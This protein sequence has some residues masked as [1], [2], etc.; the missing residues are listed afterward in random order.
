MKNFLVEIGT[1]ELPFKNLPQLAESFT[2]NLVNE[3]EKYYLCYEEVKW[4]ATPRRLAIKVTNLIQSQDSTSINQLPIF[5]PLLHRSNQVRSN[6]KSNHNFLF[7]QKKKKFLQR[8]KHQFLMSKNVHENNIIN[9]LPEIVKNSLVNISQY[10]LMRW[11]NNNIKFIR[12]IKTIILFFGKK[13][14]NSLILGIKTNTKIYGHQFI[15]KWEIHLTSAD[16]YLDVLKEKGKVLANYQER[17]EL[18]RNDLEY[19]SSLLEG[20]VDINEKILDEVTSQVEWPVILKANFEK[21]FLQIPLL[22]HIIQEKHKYFIVYDKNN[23]LLN[24]V[25]FVTNISSSNYNHVIQGNEKI[26][27]SRLCD[28]WFFFQLDRKKRLIEYLPLLNKVIFHQQL[29]TMLDKTERLQKIIVWIAIIMKKNRFF[30]ERAALLAKCDLMT[31]MVFEF[32]DI[33]GQIGMYYAFLD[34]ENYSIFHALKEQYQPSS[35]GDKLPSNSIGIILSLTDKIDTL[36]GMISIGLLPTGNKDPFALRRIC[37]GIIRIIIDNNIKV[38]LRFLIEKSIFFYQINYQSIKIVNNIINFIFGRLQSWY[39]EKGYKK[40]NIQAILSMKPTNL[41][42]LN[43]RIKA[44][45][46]FSL[47]PEYKTFI[48]IYKRISNILNKFP[49]ILYKD[50][51]FSLLETPEEIQLADISNKLINKFKFYL[52]NLHYEQILEELSQLNL[53]IDIFF[54]TVTI[55]TKSYIVKVN[56]LTLL[57]NLKKL[58]LQVADFSKI[59]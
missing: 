36:C 47:M 58:F 23:Y 42:H 6:Y 14:I 38:D 10:P 50:V 29:G 28:A 17:K 24:Q 13:I 48:L 22:K 20:K 55:N 8:K 53:S 45:E 4:Y 51:N 12:P 26:I 35:K 44:L 40:E 34:G 7:L 39:Q 43:A 2:I 16:Q 25:I 32:P 31:H 1:E 30:C 41:I 18:I 56:R 3:L 52:I 27:N 19:Q 57:S 11:G 5:F 37:L 15:G 49:I 21:K 9:I 54:K 33:Q 59:N 46:K